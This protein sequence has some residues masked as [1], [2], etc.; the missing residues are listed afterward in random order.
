MALVYQS[1]ENQNLFPVNWILTDAVQAI[2]RVSPLGVCL[3][4]AVQSSGIDMSDERGPEEL[5]M[6]FSYLAVNEVLQSM[7]NLPIDDILHRTLRFLTYDDNVSHL[8]S[9]LA[10]AVLTGQPGQFVGTY[11]L[12]GVPGTY[13]H[14]YVKSDDAV[15][16]L[17]QNIT[18]TPLTGQEQAANDWLL[19]AIENRV[20]VT[21]ARAQLLDLISGQLA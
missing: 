20:S 5:V 15:L 8:I 11:Q 2:V 16:M 21:Q 13:H 6:D 12:D 1:V 9:R 19:Q 10:Q 7:L 4:Q 18:Y 3:L 14:L 17:I